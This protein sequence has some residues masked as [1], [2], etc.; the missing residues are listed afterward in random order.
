MMERIAGWA[1]TEDQ[2]IFQATCVGLDPGSRSLFHET[3]L[4]VPAG[5]VRDGTCTHIANGRFEIIITQFPRVYR[6]LKVSCATECRV[7][8]LDNQAQV[9]DVRL[10]ISAGLTSIDWVQVTP[11]PRLNMR[12]D[13]FSADGTNLNHKVIEP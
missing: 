1:C 6:T 13:L 8:S 10:P 5:Y 11:D 3:L 9:I 2:V 12:L 4:A 7:Q